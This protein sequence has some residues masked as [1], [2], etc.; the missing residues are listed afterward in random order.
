MAAYVIDSKALIA[1]RDISGIKTVKH[2]NEP[3]EAVRITKR[4]FDSFTTDSK[5]A[6]KRFKLKGFGVM[7]QN[8]KIQ[9]RG[10]M[11]NF[12]LTLILPK[13]Q[14][15]KIFQ[16]PLNLPAIAETSDE[17]KDSGEYLLT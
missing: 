6:L 10:S 8:I 9:F 2:I 12:N 15:K 3:V 4:T 17:E 11:L 14:L 7:V 1:I 13:K 5:R 16:L